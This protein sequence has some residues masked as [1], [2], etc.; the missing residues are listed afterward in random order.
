MFSDLFSSRIPFEL[1]LR[2]LASNYNQSL[3]LLGLQVKKNFGFAPISDK[4][5]QL[6]RENSKLVPK[7]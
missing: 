6:Q 7:C 2:E 3:N 5:F 4:T 1:G